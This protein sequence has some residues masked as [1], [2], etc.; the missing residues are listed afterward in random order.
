MIDVIS[1]PCWDQKYITVSKRGPRGISLVAG[2]YLDCR[3]N[4]DGYGYNY[5][6][7]YIHNK[8]KAD[9]AIFMLWDILQQQSHV[10]IS[11]DVLH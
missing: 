2:Q 8:S 10:H 7:W 5:S 1:Y 6:L 4:N 9:E 3:G 11:W